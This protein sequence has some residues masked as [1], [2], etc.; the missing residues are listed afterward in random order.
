MWVQKYINGNH[1]IV[2]KGSESPSQ[3]PVLEPPRPPGFYR[4]YVATGELYLF[5]P[6]KENA[7]KLE[8]ASAEK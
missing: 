5:N 4:I 6:Q 2:W 7:N 1:C 3:L 8:P